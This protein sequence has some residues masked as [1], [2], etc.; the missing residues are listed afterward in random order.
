MNNFNTQRFSNSVY[1]FE[2]LQ[3][4][5]QKKW[6]L[7]LSFLTYQGTR[8]EILLCEKVDNNF[9]FSTAIA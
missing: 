8:L 4:L 1:S 2:L 5:P 7:L 9:Q 6:I 3:E